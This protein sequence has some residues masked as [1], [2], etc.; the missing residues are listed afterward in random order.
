M[1]DTLFSFKIKLISQS[2]L[3]GL[4][5]G[6]KDLPCKKIDIKLEPRASTSID[7]QGD[8]SNSEIL[9]IRF[10]NTSFYQEP[11]EPPPPNRPPPKPPNPPE[12]PPPKP[13]L[14]D[15]DCPEEAMRLSNKSMSIV[16]DRKSTR[17]NSSHVRISYAVFCLKKK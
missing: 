12:R 8:F 13:P 2:S 4:K 5:F 1:S 17:L 7:F 16:R 9:K 3:K 15:E 6:N 14:L 11:P 10:I